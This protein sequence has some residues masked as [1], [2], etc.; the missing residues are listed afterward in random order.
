MGVFVRAH[1]INVIVIIKHP[2][3]RLYYPFQE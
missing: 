3:V 2:L 1:Y